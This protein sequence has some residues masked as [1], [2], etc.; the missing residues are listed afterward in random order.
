M[1]PCPFVRILIAN[2]A[3]T[4]PEKSH[5]SSS[6]YYSKLK[7]KGFPTHFSDVPS[8]AA[9][10]DAVDSKIHACF[11]LSKP[12]LEKLADKSSSLKIEIHRRTA[13]GTTGCGFVSAAKLVGCVVVQLDL[14]AI[15]ENMGK[16]V[17]QNGWVLVGGSDVKLNVN[18]RAEPDP[19]FVFLF[20]GEP[21]CSPQVFQ[22]NGNVKQPVFTCKF[23]FRNSAERILRS[24]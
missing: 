20:D 16:C 17:I 15:L 24:R 11:A 3:L 7:F 19:R 22:V 10:S 21:E 6:S 9:H 2:L 1:D 14:R 23:G 8:L 5:L 13:R 4:F 18:V 12:D